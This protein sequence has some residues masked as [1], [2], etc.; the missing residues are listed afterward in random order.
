MFWTH[1]EDDMDLHLL[2]P[3]GEIGADSDCFYDN[4]INGGLDWGEIGAANDDPSLDIDDI[5][6]TGPE[7]INIPV[8]DNGTYTIIVHDYQFSTPNYLETN[9]VTVNVFL[10]GQKAWT[11]TKPISVEDSYTRF[12]KVSWPEGTITEL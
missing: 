3:G 2:Q 11:G 5:H 1:P 10:G 4:C 12:V 8:P 6:G 7:N 9:D